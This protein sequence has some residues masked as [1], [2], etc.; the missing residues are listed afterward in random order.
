MALWK[1]KHR[2]ANAVETR[3]SVIGLFVVESSSVFH[4]NNEKLIYNYVF[5]CCS[6]EKLCVADIVL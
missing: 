6:T 5:L 2:C 3:H 4:H 1:I